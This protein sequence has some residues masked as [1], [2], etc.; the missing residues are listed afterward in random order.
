MDIASRLERVEQEIV[1]V[2]NETKGANAGCLLGAYACYRSRYSTSSYERN[3]IDFL[4]DR[5]RALL[6]ERKELI[7]Q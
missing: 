2:E 4:E 6:E 7:V 5:K 1:Q 3:Q